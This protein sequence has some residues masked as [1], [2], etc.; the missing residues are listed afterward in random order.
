[1]Q[2]RGVEAWLIDLRQRAQR[3]MQIIMAVFAILLMLSMVVESGVRVFSHPTP[4]TTS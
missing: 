3:G 2:L 4:S 1:M